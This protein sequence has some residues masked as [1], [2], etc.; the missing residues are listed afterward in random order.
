MSAVPRRRS[1]LHRG[2]GPRPSHPSSVRS[3][4]C[5]RMRA[6]R[7]SVRVQ[8]P[9]ST[10]RST[11]GRWST[12]SSTMRFNAA[13][14]VS[15]G[16]A[17]TLRSSPCRSPSVRRLGPARAGRRCSTMPTTVARVVDD[18]ERVVPSER[19]TL[20]PRGTAPASGS[21]RRRARHDLPAPGRAATGSAWNA[22]GDAHPPAGQLLRHDAVLEQACGRRGRPA[23][24][25]A[26]AAGWRCS[27]A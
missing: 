12:P 19:N 11:I 20:R 24:W 2:G 22:H 1:S 16:A 9:T 10:P 23:R 14:K 21:S 3:W 15:R 18:R 8:I 7:M 17:A 4:S 6:R 13:C 27:P 5:W 26:S 25:P